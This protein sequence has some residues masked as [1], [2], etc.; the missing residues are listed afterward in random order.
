MLCSVC[1]WI[2]SRVA[3]YK[4]GVQVVESRHLQ[5]VHVAATLP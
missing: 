3:A 2:N 4:H 5:S 1:H